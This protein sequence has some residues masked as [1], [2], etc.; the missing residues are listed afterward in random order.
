MSK[1]EIR[2][3]LKNPRHEA[4][5]QSLSRGMSA[6]AIVDG[7]I[8]KRRRTIDDQ[9]AVK[10]Q[11]ME[12][13][14]RKPEILRDDMG[15]FEQRGTGLRKSAKISQDQSPRIIE[16]KTVEITGPFKKGQSGNPAGR[17]KGIPNKQ[18]TALKEM[19]LAALDKVGGQEYLARLAIENSSAFC[20]LL[21]KILPHTLAADADSHGGGVK[22]V[23]ERHIIHPDGHR[24]IECKTPKQL[25]PSSSHSLPSD[26]QMPGESIDSDDKLDT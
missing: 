8:R 5:A 16:K 25:P 7:L 17:P 18:T 14:L 26:D 23:F 4:F 10:K 2:P 19:V 11:Q 15:R 13:L 1:Q 24:E 6:S 22:V 3:A 21:G 9:V 20:A 12:S